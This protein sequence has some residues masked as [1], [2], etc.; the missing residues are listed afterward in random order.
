M[1]RDHGFTVLEAIVVLGI[2]S[3]LTAGG[4]VSLADVIGSAR[5]AGAA[6]TMATRLR[7]ARERALAGGA[8]VEVRFDP[9]ARRWTARDADGVVIEGGGLVP[10]ISFARLPARGRILFGAIGT[11]ENATV[12]LA[13]GARQRSVIVNQRGRV[14]LQ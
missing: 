9:A 4:V 1:R 13:A 8:A 6:R 12:T 3:V 5:V 14:R 10:G 7:L 11:A 2:A